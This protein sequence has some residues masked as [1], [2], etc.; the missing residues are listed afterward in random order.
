MEVLMKEKSKEVALNGRVQGAQNQKHT[1]GPWHVILTG[2][3]GSFLIPE[4]ARH[5]ALNMDDGLDGHTVSSANANLIAACPELLEACKLASV[6]AL[7][8]HVPDE[9][10]MDII[11]AAIAKAE[12]RQ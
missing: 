7:Q 3:R 12:G 11:F 2:T 10:E 6:L 4:A 1:P 5:E 9:E 8:H